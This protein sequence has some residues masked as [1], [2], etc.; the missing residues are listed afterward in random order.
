VCAPSWGLL[1]IPVKRGYSYNEDRYK[2]V[3]L[4]V[5]YITHLGRAALASRLVA[6]DLAMLLKGCVCN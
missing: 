1:G 5:D 3:L 4:Y 6:V 2:E